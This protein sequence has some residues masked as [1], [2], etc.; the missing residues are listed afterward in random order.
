MT[1]LIEIDLT[2]KEQ[3]DYIRQY[4]TENMCPESLEQY[5]Y[6]LNTTDSEAEA[7]K[8]AIL[9]EFINIALRETIERAETL[10]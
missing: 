6:V 9:N 2:E 10:S 8:A 5:I 1:E 7:S 4:I 3:E